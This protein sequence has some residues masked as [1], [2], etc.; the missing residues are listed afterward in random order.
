MAVNIANGIN[1]YWMAIAPE[2]KNHLG[3]IRDWSNLKL[4][5]EDGT[6]WVKDFTM[7]QVG[8]SALLQIPFKHIY[9]TKEHLLFEQNSTVPTRKM[10]TGLLWT[11]IDRALPLTLATT[12]LDNAM[13]LPKNLQATLIPATT[14]QEAIAILATIEDVKKYVEQAPSI[15]LQGLRWVLLETGVF[16]M[17]KPLLPIN[18]KTFWKYKDFLIPSGYDFELPIL[19]EIISNTINADKEQYILWNLKNEYSA[20][21]KEQLQAFNLSSFRL[22]TQAIK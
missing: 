4:A 8:A 21:D 18:G 19:N 2:H 11:P 20:F 1:N 15:R 5:Q 10:P 22:T 13:S 14:E 16:I 6:I 12:V 7:E 17:G 9:Y 3:H